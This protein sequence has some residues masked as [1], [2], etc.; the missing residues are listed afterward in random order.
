MV[1]VLATLKE[2]NAIVDWD[3]YED[4]E[5]EVVEVASTVEKVSLIYLRNISIPFSQCFESILDPVFLF[6][7]R[8]PKWLTQF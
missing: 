8:K 1:N 7:K 5:E 4:V 6:Y 3:M 2:N